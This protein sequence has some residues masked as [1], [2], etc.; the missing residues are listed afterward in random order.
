MNHK[1]LSLLVSLQALRLGSDFRPP[2]PQVAGREKD[3]ETGRG[4]Q[5]GRSSGSLK[6]NLSRGSASGSGEG[7]GQRR[8]V[9]SSSSMNTTSSASRNSNSMQSQSLGNSS[10]FKIQFK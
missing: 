8:P 1:L 7:Q 9:A 2:V 4:A 5:G 6:L 10:T 3:R